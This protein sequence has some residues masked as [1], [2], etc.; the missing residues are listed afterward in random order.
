MLKKFKTLAKDSFTYSFGIVL[1]NIIGFFLIPIYTRIFSPEQF[2]TIDVLLSINGFL[3]TFLALSTDSSMTRYFYDSDDFAYR[4][5]IISTVFTFRLLWG[6][7]IVAICALSVNLFNHFLFAESVPVF[8]FYIVFLAA[9]FGVILS[10]STTLYRLLMQPKRYI[11]ITILQSLLAPVLIIF[12]VIYV[13]LGIFGYL[14]GYSLA[15]LLL[16]VFSYIQLHQYLALEYSP[17]LMKKVLL[18]GIPLMP[19]TISIW[20]IN[21][22][23]RFF[24]IQF[25]GLAA[26]GLFAIGSKISLS[27]GLITSAFRLSWTPYAQSIVN[28]SDAKHFFQMV[29]LA[30]IV[31]L[32]FVILI[33]TGLS[34]IVLQ[35]FT[36]PEYYDGYVVI[37]ILA[38]SAVFYGFYTISSLGTWFA[39]KTAYV[40]VAIVLSAICNIIL[41]F[42]LIPVYGILGAAIAT[43]F[44]QIFG[45]VIVL[46]IGEHVYP[47]GFDFGKLSATVLITCIGMSIELYL[48]GSNMSSIYTYGAI[49]FLW[50]VVGGIFL[51]KIIGMET[52]RKILTLI[53]SKMKSSTTHG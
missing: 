42:L 46:Y 1:G 39:E 34:K 16:C 50:L 13:G 10:V 2:G 27:I 29:S 51:V 45:N 3:V 20:I 24:L 4:K 11:T 5:K 28:H 43:L 40:T 15:I 47:I 12:F 6:I 48:L 37:G 35:V 23:D 49:I 31:G 36:T 26:V 22:S 41:N 9:F 25:A 18:F 44:G 14:L 53:N 21:F 8:Y 30:Y 33:L 52:S 32:S 38:Y 7:V 17:D 19:T